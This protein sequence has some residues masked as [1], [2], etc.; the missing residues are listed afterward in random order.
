M[1][2]WRTFPSLNLL[3]FFDQMGILT[4]ALVTLWVSLTVASIVIL[5]LVTCSTAVID[6]PFTSLFYSDL[7][8]LS[9]R[10]FQNP[11]S[12]FNLWPLFRHHW[13]MKIFE[14]SSGVMCD[15]DLIN[16]WHRSYHPCNSEGG[17]MKVLLL[18]PPNQQCNNLRNVLVFVC[19]WI[20]IWW[21]L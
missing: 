17:N 1:F 4:A 3:K 19:T 10:I 9:G 16:Q 13:S 5:Y 7:K 6:M 18:Y 20:C 21:G 11:Y 15:S 12:T 8:N 14:F 2:S